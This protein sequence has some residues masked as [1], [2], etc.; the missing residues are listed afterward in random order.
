MPDRTMEPKTNFQSQNIESLVLYPL[1]VKSLFMTTTKFLNLITAPTCK[2]QNYIAIRI[3]V[4]LFPSLFHMLTDQAPFHSL[5]TITIIMTYASQFLLNIS[6]QFSLQ[7]IH[8]AALTA[9]MFYI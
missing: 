4:S 9:F 7:L 6:N 5:L 1:H 3:P 8:R 2:S